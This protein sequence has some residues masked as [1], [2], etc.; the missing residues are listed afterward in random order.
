MN[1][2]IGNTIFDKINVPYDT[3]R[4]K[5][6]PLK[7]IVKYYKSKLKPG[8][9]LWWIDAE[10]NNTPSNI[11]IRIWNNLSLKEKQDLKIKA[12]I[13]FPELFSNNSNKF[14]RLAIWL[15]TRE[16]VVCPNIRDLFTAGGKADFILN[17]VLLKNSPR[18]FINLFSNINQIIQILQTINPLELKEHWGVNTSEKNKLFDWIKIVDAQAKKIPDAKHLNVEKILLG[19]VH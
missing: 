14:G 16:A 9:E 5:E 6:N 19:L 8:E 3:L 17:G 10:S 13:Y 1:L 4:K 7:S 12:M 18:I 15:I 2:D 11:V